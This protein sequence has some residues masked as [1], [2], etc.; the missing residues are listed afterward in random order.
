[1]NL[2]QSVDFSTCFIHCLI[3]ISKHKS[4][5]QKQ[6]QMKRK[7]ESWQVGAGDMF[8][9]SLLLLTIL[10]PEFRLTEVFYVLV[11]AS[12]DVKHQRLSN[13]L[14]SSCLMWVFYT[15]FNGRHC[16][17][18]CELSPSGQWREKLEFRGV[19]WWIF[20]SATSFYFYVYGLTLRV[21]DKMVTQYNPSHRFL[22]KFPATKTI[23]KDTQ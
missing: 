13:F 17:L 7:M 18:S 10:R 20:R 21:G 2:G 3:W 23:S 12:S 15:V 4:D 9:V 16:K 19:L 5:R 11:Y 8:T 22:Q 6:V 14:Q 1:M